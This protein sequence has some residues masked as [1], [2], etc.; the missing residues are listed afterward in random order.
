MGCVSE[1]VGIFPCLVSFGLTFR[2]FDLKD[3]DLGVYL[4][5]VTVCSIPAFYY[6][7][8]ALYKTILYSAYTCT[9]QSGLLQTAVNCGKLY[10]SNCVYSEVWLLLRTFNSWT[11][12]SQL[13]IR[14]NKNGDLGLE[15]DL[16]NL[17]PL[18]LGKN[19]C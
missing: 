14:E 4:P 10:M 1:L 18:L 12:F 2:W 11:R 7:F 8:H 16:V 15:D 3:I 13:R 5:A 17:E 9:A 19:L 6:Y